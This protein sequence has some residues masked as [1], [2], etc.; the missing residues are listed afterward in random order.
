MKTRVAVAV[1]ATK[2]T[3]APA[4]GGAQ[5]RTINNQQKAARPRQQKQ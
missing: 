1:V 3:V 5:L 4:M 2:T